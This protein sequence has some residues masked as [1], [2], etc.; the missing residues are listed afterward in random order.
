MLVLALNNFYLWF[1]CLDTDF[2]KRDYRIKIEER[3]G[4][5]IDD[6]SVSYFFNC[7]SFSY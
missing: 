3:G 5:I 4:E 1:I 6:F 7:L 2:Q